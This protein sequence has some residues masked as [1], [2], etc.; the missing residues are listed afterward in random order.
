MHAQA[1]KVL[2][3]KRIAAI[4]EILEAT[5]RNGMDVT[6]WLHWFLQQVEAAASKA[7]ETVGLTLRKAR[8]WLRHQAHDLNERQRE[9]LNRLLD[10]GPEGFEGAMNTR[11]YMGMTETSRATAY[12]ELT[13]LVSKGCL[14]PTG[15]GGRSSGYALLWD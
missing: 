2:P 15:G 9:V 13:E 6:E 8:F 14:R 3:M 1:G 11:K 12:R 5:Q 7:E 4:Y 10:A